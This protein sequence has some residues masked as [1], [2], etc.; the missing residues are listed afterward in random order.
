MKPTANKI[1]VI[2]FLLCALNEVFFI[3][4]YLLAFTS[5][6]EDSQIQSEIAM[7]VKNNPN[8]A[9]AFETARANKMSSTWPYRLAYISFLGML[10][11]QVTNVLQLVVAC[12]RLADSDVEMRRAANIAAGEKRV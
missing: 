12:K 4:L 3:A 11:K 7:V 5:P 6:P 9:V 1:Q 10:V 8:S 2:L